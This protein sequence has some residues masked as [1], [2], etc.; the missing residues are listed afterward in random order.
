MP[1]QAAADELSAGRDAMARGDWSR[2]RELLQTAVT[3]DDSGEA[4][5]ALGWAAWWTY[6]GEVAIRAR[7]NAFRAYRGAGDALGAAR[8]AAWLANDHREYRG[9][10]AVGL[11]WLRRAHR[12]IDDLP[13]VEEH[14]WLALNEG[15]FAL[16]AGELARA[17]ELAQGASEIGRTLAVADLEAVGLAQ[18]GIAHVA[19]GDVELG[20]RRL[21][22]ATAIARGEDLRLPISA[23]WAL[24]YLVSACE[25]VGDTERA[26]QWCDAMLE[27]A[28]QWQGRQL[29][30]VC[31]TSYGR[32]LATRGDW[33][34]AERT[35]TAAIDDLVSSRPGQAAS[36][37]VRLGDLRVRQ[38]RLDEARELY[39]RA[40][41]HN[42]AIIG[43]G[44][45]ELDD[46]DA[47]A[48]RDAADRVLR[49]LPPEAML[50]RLPALEL[51][52]RALAALGDF[53]TAGETCGQVAAMAR[54]L[55]TP[56]LR[57]RAHRVAA[58]LGVAHGAAEQAR[59]DAEDAIDCLTASS[60]P[61]EAAQARLV[62]ARALRLLGREGHAAEEATAARAA[63]AELGAMRGVEQA[64]ALLAAGRGAAGA[65]G[66][67][68]G[69]LTPREIEIL[70][71]VAQGLGDAEIAERLVV[72]PHTVHRHVAN[73]RSKLRLSSRAAAV[74]YAS[75][76]GLI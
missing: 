32:V 22:E 41:A 26:V 12:L 74:A 28:E 33:D 8:V 3:H 56:Y 25:G 6:D 9:D 72:S 18:E 15:S 75:R 67:D 10:I 31:R 40:G 17:L 14:G 19:R 55:G 34:D 76:A 37:Y 4:W 65:N 59:R 60:A 50:D 70:K 48:A 30:A 29:R 38:G 44:E 54:R 62:L 13:R 49:K 36:G 16:E 21:D 68:L 71:L 63:F 57:G 47:I 2:A 1:R 66:R 42:G 51:R 43:L 20:M 5:E 69:E 52:V 64:D 27:Y 73:I 39:R 35:L 24:C 58:E 45:L 46:G 23:G 7:E 53:V 11:G 61:Y